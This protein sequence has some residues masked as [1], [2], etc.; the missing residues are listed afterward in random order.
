MRWLKPPRG[1]TKLNTNGL[2]FGNPIKAG[3]GSILRCSNED[4]IAGFAQKLGNTTSTIA[5]LWALKD[6]LI[7]V[8]QLGIENICIKMDADFIV[9]LV[10]SASMFNLMLEPLLTDCKNLIETFSNSLVAYVFR[11]TNSCADRL[12]RM[13]TEFIFDFLT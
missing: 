1:W 13:G 7:V 8:K 6:G 11:E 2:V 5:E 9:H 10:S 4:W 3:G 12:V